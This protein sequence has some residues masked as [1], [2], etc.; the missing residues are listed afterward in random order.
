MEVTLHQVRV[1]D[2]PL[3][4]QVAHSVTNLLGTLQKVDSL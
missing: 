2:G 1:M 3:A 4:V